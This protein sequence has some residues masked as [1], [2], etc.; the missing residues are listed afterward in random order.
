MCYSTIGS[1]VF[2]NTHGRGS[3]RALAMA[4]LRPNWD[5]PW[6]DRANLRLIPDGPTFERT[7]MYVQILRGYVLAPPDY[8]LMRW[9]T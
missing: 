3:C 5:H 8:R 1:E 7:S 2:N 4:R 6:D 9:L